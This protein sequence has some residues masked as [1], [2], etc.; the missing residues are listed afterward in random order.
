MRQ[1]C[2]TKRYH[3]LNSAAAILV[4]LMSSPP[5]NAAEARSQTSHE[6]VADLP[7]ADVA[8]KPLHLDLHLPRDTPRPPLVIYIHGGGWRNGDRK[9]TL[10]K[11][12]FRDPILNAG[13]ALAS[14]D[15]RLSDTAT[16]P[17]QIHDCKG[18]VRWLRAH[19]GK[20]GYDASRI[21]AVGTSAGGHLAMLL[22]ASGGVEAL[23]GAVGDH[24]D[25]PSDVQA[26]V[27]FFGP[28]DFLL[29]SRT[30]TR[31]CNH[32]GGPVYQ[33]LGGS[34]RKNTDLAKLASPLRHVS[35]GDPPVLIVHGLMDS[36]VNPG[37]SIELYQ[38]YK[39][40][41]LPVELHLLPDAGHGIRQSAKPDIMPRMIG[42][43]NAHLRG[44]VGNPAPSTRP[45]PQKQEKE[46]A[47]D[48]PWA[49]PNAS[50]RDDRD[51]PFVPDGYQRVFTANF[52]DP[53]E[54]FTRKGHPRFTTG[55]F[56][57]SGENDLNTTRRLGGNGELQLYFDKD[58]RFQGTEFDIDPFVVRDGVLSIIADR[59]SD[60][61]VE[62]LRPLKGQ[63]K[64]RLIKYSSGML[65]TETQDRG[66]NGFTQLYGYWE[67]RARLP[68]GRGL[69]P[70]FWLVTHTH[71]YWDEI[72]IFEVLGHEPDK[73]Y[74]TT[75]FHDGGGT[76]NKNPKNKVHTGVDTSQRFHVY[77][78]Q[79]TRDALI[80]T[81]DGEK[82]LRTGH[83][84]E[85]PLYTI[86]NL[87]VGGKWPKDPDET[88]EFPA[89]MDIDYLRI[90]SPPPQEQPAP[91]DPQQ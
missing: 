24:S 90:Y 13:Y 68:K 29:R 62:A 79:I 57:L 46:A 12:G 72:D 65:S 15:Y 18:A 14:I 6:L 23:E 28:V 47:P 9:R 33:L 63:K 35:P 64:N 40:E 44:G 21:A 25:Q 2:R 76:D 74:M 66:G 78:M 38:K 69:W 37:Q 75:H 82:T 52:L 1:L 50:R 36:T 7:Y 16:F 54:E 87:A 84:L 42:F 59:L 34:V 60:D 51:S 49:P 3:V 26:V 71:E 8:G 48:S 19:A 45:A 43:L 17:A 83:S 27:D 81:L 85:V 22:G 73:I 41:G 32:P 39:K 4:M 88:T 5:T 70:A 77:G 55:H 11:V 30:Q 53:T 86:V 67:L 80:W 31:K 56:R 20:Y 10:Q 89:S 58:F 91:G 61:R